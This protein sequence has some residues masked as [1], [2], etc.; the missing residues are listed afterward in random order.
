MQ[1]EVGIIGGQGVASG[2]VS[3]AELFTCGGGG[4]GG[5]P[6]SFGGG[7][8]APGASVT[9]GKPGNCSNGSFTA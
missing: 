6:G 2:W 7:P 9:S 5:G 3:D 8:G 1:K 4:V